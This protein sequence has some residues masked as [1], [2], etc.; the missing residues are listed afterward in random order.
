[1]PPPQ[2]PE[3]H[4]RDADFH[5]Y[6]SPAGLPRQW[7]RGLTM[8]TGL[9][10]RHLDEGAG[11][12]EVGCGQ[13]VLLDRLRLAGFRTVGLEPSRAAAARAADLGLMVINGEL[14]AEPLSPER[15]GGPVSAVVFSHVLE[16]LP[17]PEAALRAAAAVPGCRYVLLVQANWRGWMARKQG[18]KWHAWVPD[19]HYWHFTPAGLTKFVTNL[20]WSVAELEYSSLEHGS[21]FGTR[22]LERAGPLLDQFH[23]LVR[24]APSRST[25][26][27]NAL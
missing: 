11:V 13:G 21:K 27:T 17:N 4:Y 22:L 25:G 5:A 6:I 8:Q 24:I 10:R 16:H 15:L 12:L 1:M 19:Q 3:D 26:T 14:G 18:A 20:G 23:L 7:D 9:L 2:L